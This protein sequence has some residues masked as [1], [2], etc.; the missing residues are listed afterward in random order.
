MI[1][2]ATT[3][4]GTGKF[5]IFGCESSEVFGTSLGNILTFVDLIFVVPIQYAQSCA[6]PYL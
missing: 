3:I 2:R 6:Y 5:E 1:A 4:N